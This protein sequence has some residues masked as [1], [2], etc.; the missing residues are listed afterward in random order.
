MIM[1]SEISMKPCRRIWGR[2]N[3]D[4]GDAGAQVAILFGFQL[5]RDRR[6]SRELPLLRN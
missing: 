5:E 4:D 6:S 3:E 2:N 1:Q